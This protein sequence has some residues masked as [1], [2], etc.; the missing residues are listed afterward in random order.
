MS[1]TISS[2]AFCYRLHTPLNTYDKIFIEMQ[3]LTKWYPEEGIKI[4]SEYKKIRPHRNMS[5]SC[6]NL[7]TK[8]II[9]GRF[10]SSL[11]LYSNFNYRTLTEKK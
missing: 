10:V 11:K 5:H 4:K 1:W 6:S 3:T 8:Y 7:D 9:S 2:K